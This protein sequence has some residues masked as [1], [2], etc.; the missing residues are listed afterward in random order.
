L[1]LLF[2]RTPDVPQYV[3]TDEAKLRQ[4]LINLLNNAIKFT[5]EGGVF[6]KVKSQ[7]PQFPISNSQLHFEIEDTGVGIAPDELDSLFK[8]FVQTSSG[9]Q[10]HEGTGLGLSI[11]RQFVRLMG[12]EIAVE[13]EVGRGT[14]FRFDIQVTEVDAPDL[15]KNRQISRRII[16]L[17]PNQ[18]RYRILIADD[19]DYNRQL[20]LKLLSPLGFELQQA[21][22]GK[23]AVEIWQNWQPHLIWMDVRMPVMDGYEATRQIRAQQARGWGDGESNSTHPVNAVQHQPTVIIALTASAF[24]RQEASILAAGCNDCVRKPFREQVIF[25]KMAEYL[26]VRYVYEQNTDTQEIRKQTSRAKGKNLTSDDLAVMPAEWVAQLHQ[27]ALE[28]DADPIFQLIEQ[29]PQPHLAMAE[30]LTDLVR[31]FRFDEIL[32]LT[33]DF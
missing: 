33:E 2:D 14:T 25:E 18:P 7:N 5:S 15:E 9:Q 20:V 1:Q 13:S 16:A 28:V 11:S 3:R 4:V 10:A 17:E 12:G 31:R 29:I 23:E 21:S 24:E 27:A 30:G 26:G 8:P 6:L 19:N 32:E 22:S